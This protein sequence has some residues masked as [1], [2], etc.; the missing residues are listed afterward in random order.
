MLAK[1]E[2]PA[3]VL[4][5]LAHGL[6]NKFLHHPLAALGRSAGGE[7]EALTTALEKLYADP[8]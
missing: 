6:A 7:R 3:K 8:E 1:G 5:A 4:E 2:D